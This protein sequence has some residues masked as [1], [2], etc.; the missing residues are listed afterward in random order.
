MISDSQ[1]EACLRGERL[2]QRE[3]FGV[4]APRAFRVAARYVAQRA[5]AEDVV[6]EAMARVFAKL[7]GFD[8]G[9]GSIEAWS[10]R[11]F[12]NESLRYLRRYGRLVL[13]ESADRE[14][15]TEPA[16]E[17]LALQRLAAADLRR[18]LLALPDG[19][20]AVFNLH[21]VE[22]YSHAEI[23]AALGVQPATSRSQLAR[24]KALLQRRL[25][26]PQPTPARTSPTSPTKTI[27]L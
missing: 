11:I 2:A 21:E 7:A 1:I 4:L 18:H 27:A 22:G 19:Y 12:V 8:A 3:L 10:H 14:A 24:A 23:A 9:R 26:G 16:A 20:R 6:Q 13:D 5:S 17:P 25:R 15:A